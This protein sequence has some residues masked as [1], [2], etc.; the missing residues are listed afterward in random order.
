MPTPPNSTKL[1]DDVRNLMRRRHYSRRTEKSYCGWITQY[2]KFHQMR[3]RE[4]LQDGE[5][6]LI[7]EM[8]GF[9]YP[10]KIVVAVE[11]ERMT[12]I[13]NYPLKKGRSR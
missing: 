1:L 4:D 7:K 2:V 3:G 13:T 11:K 8:P 9:L 6:E 10:I 5:H 12:V